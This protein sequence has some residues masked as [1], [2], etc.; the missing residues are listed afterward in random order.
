MMT[1]RSIRALAA[2]LPL[3]ACLGCRTESATQ[4]AS[5]PPSPP[6]DTAPTPSPAR[7]TEPTAAP[8]PTASA[9]PGRTIRAALGAIG[10]I[11]VTGEIAKSIDKQA[12]VDAL[13]AAIGQDQ[14]P[15]GPLRRCPDI[16]V[17]A[18][19]D[20]QGTDKG[21]VGICSFN[22]IGPEFFTGDGSDRKGIKLADEAAFRKALGIAPSEPKN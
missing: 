17:L 18:L 6:A 1:H 21:K 16:V 8:T 7:T 4:K 15:N 2:C 22:S 13:L 19:K 3:L 10:K 20:D 14:V 11:E 9:A 5:D 12:D